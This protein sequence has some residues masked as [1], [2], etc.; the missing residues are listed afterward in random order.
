MYKSAANAWAIA[1]F[2]IL[3][4]CTAP[5]VS[6]PLEEPMAGPQP[7]EPVA[8]NTSMC[9]DGPGQKFLG[10]QATQAVGEQIMQ[11][12]G[13]RTFQWVSPGMAITMDYQPDRVR[14]SHDSSRIITEITCG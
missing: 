6:P 12:T 1:P 13:A 10:Q 2:L 5:A 7:G 9:T 8:G 4:A 3:S 14:V 11:Q